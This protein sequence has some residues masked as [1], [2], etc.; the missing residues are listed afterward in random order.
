MAAASEEW[1]KLDGPEEGCGVAIRI[2]P[3]VSHIGM[4]LPDGKFIHA[5]QRTGITVARLDDVQWINRIAG[6][7]RYRRK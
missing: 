4:V 1:E 7:Y 5:N 2:G 6:Y 3:F